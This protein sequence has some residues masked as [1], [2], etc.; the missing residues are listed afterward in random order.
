[1]RLGFIG[2]GLMGRPMAL[3]L[4]RAGHEVIVHS[5]SAG[6][7]EA[8]VAAGATAAASPAE[9]AAQVEWLG[10]CLV[11]PAQCELIYLGARGVAASGNRNLLCTDFATIAP[12]TSLEIGARMAKAGM[13][14][15]DAPI[16]GGPRGASAA[17]LSI[18]VGAADADF[19][20]ARPIFEHLGKNIFHMG[21]PGT[22]LSTKLCNNLITGTLHVLIGE[23]MVLG[24]SAG[25]DPRKLYEVL[26][27]STARSNTLERMVPR[28]V[29][30]RQFAPDATIESMLKDFDSILS[31][32]DAL[33]VRLLLAKVAQACYREASD[34]GHSQKDVSAVILPMEEI[35]GVQ[36][37]PA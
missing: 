6:P 32:G 22:G 29:L 34:Q 13:R 15:I 16:S 14:Y 35:A 3:N 27:G 8:L 7:V 37:G 11:T 25:I 24:T 20:E 26:V 10:T 5:R 30:P 12:A 33:G 17:T 1:M 4:V 9:V 19:A 18:I 36:V 28:F 31:T 2:L 21:P 23:A